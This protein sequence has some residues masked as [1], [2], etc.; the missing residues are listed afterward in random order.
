MKTI[1]LINTLPACIHHYG[2]NNQRSEALKKQQQTTKGDPPT[3][4]KPSVLSG[5]A[6]RYAS[7]SKALAQKEQKTK[8]TKGNL[9]T[10]SKTLRSSYQMDRHFSGVTNCYASTSKALARVIKFRYS[11]QAA[12]LPAISSFKSYCRWHN[13]GLTNDPWYDV[14]HFPAKKNV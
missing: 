2:C 12:P 5:L 13:L 9:P 8:P 7:T 14:R 11:L 6:N 1:L 10:G 3:G 4:S